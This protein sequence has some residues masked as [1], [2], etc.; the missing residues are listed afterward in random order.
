[1]LDFIHWRELIGLGRLKQ[2]KEARDNLLTS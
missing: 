2:K 1:V